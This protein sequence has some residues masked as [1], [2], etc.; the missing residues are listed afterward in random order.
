VNDE[1]VDLQLLDKLLMIHREHH[2]GVNKA[3]Q[4]LSLDDSRE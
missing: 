1:V 2:A 4:G 3:T